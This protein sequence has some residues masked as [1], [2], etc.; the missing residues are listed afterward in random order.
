[1]DIPRGL[2]A[3]R[4]GFNS[5]RG[6]LFWSPKCSFFKKSKANLD[7]KEILRPRQR[8]LAV[9]NKPYV[10]ANSHVTLDVM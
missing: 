9:K 3:R 7:Q 5:R 1:M 10:K 4:P 8:S 6:S 2:M